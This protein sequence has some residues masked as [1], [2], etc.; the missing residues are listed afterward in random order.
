MAE[1]VASSERV[2]LTQTTQSAL[3][4]FQSVRQSQQEK[5]GQVSELRAAS[6][7]LRRAL[8][9]RLWNNALVPA[10]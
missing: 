7:A 8:E 5:K 3:K 2:G 1:D 9:R 10:G 4:A 6:K